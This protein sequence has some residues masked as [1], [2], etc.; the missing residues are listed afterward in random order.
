MPGRS[1]VESTK[2][3]C[4][5][6]LPVRKTMGSAGCS[7]RRQE[8]NRG[9][10]V[11]LLDPNDSRSGFLSRYLQSHG[12]GAHHV[13]FM[14]DDIH[15][16]LACLRDAQVPVT[17][18]DLDY[19][20]WREVFIHPRSGLGTVVQIASSIYTYP[21]GCQ[22]GDDHGPGADAP[23]PY[24]PKSRLVAANT[25]RCRQAGL[26]HGEGHFDGCD[27]C[28]VRAAPLRGRP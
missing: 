16:T 7:G 15:E 13:T 8:A 2:L 21:A 20:P 4:C 26:R 10:R 22:G 24:R 14:V 18:I 23:S 6:P 28:G 3:V 11:E 17:Q 19:A 9:I 5:Y 1:C 27:R 12:E 25:G